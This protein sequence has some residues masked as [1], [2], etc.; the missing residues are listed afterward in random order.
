MKLG[1]LPFLLALGVVAGIVLLGVVGSLVVGRTDLV[2]IPFVVAIAFAAVYLYASH[3]PEPPPAASVADEPFDD[4]VEEADR[5]SAGSVTGPTPAAEAG[6]ATD[7]ASPAPA[8]SL[9]EAPVSTPPSSGA[10]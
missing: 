8:P 6:S 7:G 9:P 3:V 1:D 2:W 10:G 4:P 5:L